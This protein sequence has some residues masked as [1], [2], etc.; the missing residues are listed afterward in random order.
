MA[1]DLIALGRADWALVA[2]YDAL[3]LHTHAGFG[4]IRAL[5][6][7][8]PRPFAPDRA[9]MLLGDGFAA[10]VLEPVERA[11]AAGRQV[12]ARLL[13]YG[14][15]ADAHH[16]TQPHPDGLGAALAMRRALA[17][18]GLEPGAVDAIHVH[19]TATPT[20]DAAEV[21]AMRAV[22]GERLAQVPLCASKPALGHT[23][24]GAG[25][26]EAVIS[27]MLLEHQALLPT[28]GPHVTDPELGAIEVP[29]AL[30]PAALGVVMSNSF[31]FGG[32]NTSLILG[33]A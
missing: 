1:A 16:L 10:M 21:A 32:C 28:L 12:R 26:V 31:G 15:S 3:D 20:N 11:Q 17:K 4:A 14:E 2:G 8:G 25:A 23:L 18:A 19:C 22:F 24:G 27:L 5:D 9:G 29:R 33:A 13:G 7:E 6:P 30:T